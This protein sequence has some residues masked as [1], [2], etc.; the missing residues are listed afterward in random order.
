[1]LFNIVK[2]KVFGEVES[3]S[4]KIKMVHKLMQNEL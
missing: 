4:Y 2:N 3:S 1:M